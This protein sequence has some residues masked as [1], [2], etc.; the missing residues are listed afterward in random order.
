MFS[1]VAERTETTRDKLIDYPA[2]CGRARTAMANRD[3]ETLEEV[4]HIADKFDKAPELRAIMAEASVLFAQHEELC[5]RGRRAAYHRDAAALASFSA[6]GMASA[7]LSRVAVQV[8]EAVDEHQ[9]T[10]AWF[11]HAIATRSVVELHAGI[12]E[13]GRWKSAELDA[14]AQQAQEV[15]VEHAALLEA[16]RRAID[17]RDVRA[18]STDLRSFE[19]GWN[20]SDLQELAATAVELS[21]LHT[22]LCAWIVRACDNRDAEAL[23]NLDV[24]GWQSSELDALAARARGIVRE[25]QSKCLHFR[26]CVRLGDVKALPKCSAEGW[27][28]YELQGLQVEAEQTLAKHA[29]LLVDGRDAVQ[30]HDVEALRLVAAGAGQYELSRDAQRIAE[31]VRVLLSKHD[32]LRDRAKDIIHRG[33][34]AQLGS[35]TSVGWVS[36]ELEA[37]AAEAAKR[38]AAHEALCENAQKAIATKDSKAL[39]DVVK[40]HELAAWVSERLGPLAAAAQELLEV[41]GNLLSSGTQA[42]EERDVEGLVETVR[43]AESWSC[44]TLAEIRAKAQAL[45]SEHQELIDCGREACDTKE[46]VGIREVATIRTP[47]VSPALYELKAEAVA[48]VYAYDDLIA[49]AEAAVAQDLPR[50]VAPVEF[51]VMHLR[52]WKGQEFVALLHQAEVLLVDFESTCSV[53]DDA[54]ATGNIPVLQGISAKLEAWES[55]R[56][57][58]VAPRAR[59]ILANWNDILVRATAALTDEPH[60]VNE[61]RLALDAKGT[62]KSVELSDVINR[63]DDVLADYDAVVAQA[64]Q[65][66][67]GGNVGGLRE[68]QMV[69]VSNR[70]RSAKLDELCRQTAERLEEYEDAFAMLEEAIQTRHIPFL[71]DGIQQMPSWAFAKV[72]RGAREKRR[73]GMANDYDRHRTLIAEARELEESYA[74]AVA[75]IERIM[76]KAAPTGKRP[77]LEE[78]LTEL[79]EVCGIPLEIHDDLLE[80]AGRPRVR[81]ARRNSVLASRARLHW[82]YLRRA[83]NVLGKLALDPKGGKLSGEDLRKIRG[84]EKMKMV[85]HGVINMDGDYGIDLHQDE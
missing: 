47:W 13:A 22:A 18:L 58:E 28:S 69:Y 1:I 37:A 44:E 45:V 26:E 62:F 11:Q 51:A 85:R 30:R 9:K 31:E 52:E 32:A 66:L 48:L 63:A 60:D 19:V 61:L 83:Y 59:E 42:I 43:E 12:A 2:L 65:A 76:G 74:S 16:V 49:T 39:R 80:S 27:A 10:C 36:A 70:F 82:G 34:V 25:H 57:R 7:E 3:V 46:I 6:A 78:A 4:F 71:V 17:A 38:S 84:R 24:N 75:K 68:V 77:G 53:L 14:L 23:A 81:R 72:K 79:D 21:R 56:L 73:G 33:D 20:S 29:R 8:Q 55:E 64:E 67:D 41:H 50:A 15:L 35:I 40:R 5:D 54:L